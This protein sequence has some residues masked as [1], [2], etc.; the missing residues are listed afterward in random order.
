MTLPNA[1][2]RTFATVSATV[3]TVSLVACS[4]DSGGERSVA[5]GGTYTEALGADPGNLHPLTTVEQSTNTVISFAYDSLVNIGSDNEVVPQ[6]AETWEVQPDS[7]TFTLRDG[8]TCE[9]GTP[10][11]AE[12]V[13][14]NFE[15]VKDPANGST[16]LGSGLPSGDIEVAADNEARTVTLTL[17]RPYGFL[18]TGAGLIPIVCPTGLADPTLLRQETDGTGPFVLTEYVADDHIRMEVREDYR[19]GPDGVGSDREGFPDEVMFR[20]VQ[21]PTTAVNLFLSQELTSVSPAGPDAARVQG[22][23]FFELDSAAGPFNMFFNQRDGHPTA[24]RDVR[25]AIATAIDLDDIAEVVTQ[26]EGRRATSLTALSPDPCDEDTVEGALPDFDADA[27]ASALDAAGWTDEDG[28]RVKDGEPL[29]VTIGY[30]TDEPAIGAAMELVGQ[31]LEEIGV[32]VELSGQG[33]NAYLATLFEGVEWD[34]A[35]LNVQ[36]AYPTEFLSFAQPPVSPEG[37]NFAAIDNPEYDRLT[38]QA[39]ETPGEEGCALWGEAEQA[40]FSSVDVVPISDSIDTTFARDAEFREG[41][42]SLVE[43][44]S[45]TLFEQ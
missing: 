27:A 21:N 17:E 3:V 33:S 13:A 23:D 44:T 30:A 40:L 32:D 31:Q 41:V 28:V 37:Q 11:D 10:L 1:L 36:I 12:A 24:D 45:I 2:R 39:T 8:V 4:D 38:E 35:F 19:W 6:L 7:I 9:D 20:V 5:D 16:Y 15:W 22:Q 26:G 43:P 25:E 14:A 42:R 18:L 34:I 29:E